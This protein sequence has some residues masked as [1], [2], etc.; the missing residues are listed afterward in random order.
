M[1]S[2]LHIAC[3]AILICTVATGNSFA[4]TGSGK[5]TEITSPLQGGWI[6]TD[7]ADG[8]N[9]LWKKRV[10]READCREKINIHLTRPSDSSDGR[11]FTRILLDGIAAVKITAFDPVDDSFTTILSYHSLLVNAAKFRAP[12]S[13]NILPPINIGDVPVVFSKIRIK[14]DWVFLKDEGIMV[15]RIE[16]IA[17][18]AQTINDT[19]LIEEKPMFWIRYPDCRSYLA[20]FKTWPVKVE[21]KADN[22]VTWEEYFEMRIFSSKIIKVGGGQQ[23]EIFVRE[24]KPGKVNREIRRNERRKNKPQ[25][26]QESMA[27]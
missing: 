22:W 12:D 10:W 14:E 4:Q 13:G 2:I 15:V 26:T 19:G 17:P 21:K 9:V 27:D 25:H 23:D 3:S 8:K 20:Q 16:G 5:T 24:R 6:Q 1:R 7:S 18:V 11:S